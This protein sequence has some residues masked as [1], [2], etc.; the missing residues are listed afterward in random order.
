M[1]NETFQELL[2][3]QKGKQ[4]KEQVAI[5]EAAQD[6]ATNQQLR[7]TKNMAQ[8]IKGYTDR[9]GTKIKPTVSREAISVVGK[10]QADL[11]SI[12]DGSFSEFKDVMDKYQTLVG[13]LDKS[14]TFNP[15][16][17][18]YVADIITPVLAE[19]RAEANAFTATRMG[20]KDL[21]KQFKPLKLAAR[22]FG[23]IPILGKAIEKKIERTESGEQELRRAEVQKR[24]T[25]ATGARKEA[26]AEVE[27]ITGAAGFDEGDLMPEDS[28]FDEGPIVQRPVKTK[29]VIEEEREELSARRVAPFDTKV[30]KPTASDEEAKEEQIAIQE[31][32]ARRR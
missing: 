5:S 19:V 13:E 23:N 28:G 22:V 1:A 3:E 6:F 16:E 9:S 14:R 27:N 7:V 11:D 32:L 8:K 15:D 31:G 17:R 21:M 18:A 29:S 20:F 10:F 30:S 24:K 25:E 12:A 2:S 4:D 26:L